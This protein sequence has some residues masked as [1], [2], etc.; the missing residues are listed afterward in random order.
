[1][2]PIGSQIRAWR[3]FRCLSQEELA[4]MTGLPRPNLSALEQSRHD[5][6]LSTL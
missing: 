5:C 2:K 3:N 6:T 1:M 4:K